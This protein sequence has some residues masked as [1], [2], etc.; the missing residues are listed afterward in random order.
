MKDNRNNVLTAIIPFKSAFYCVECDS[1]YNFD[2]YK[3]EVCPRCANKYCVAL[4]N[5][6][7][8]AMANS[9]EK[10]EG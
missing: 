7:N 4:N 8:L 3:T 1:I 5:F 10:K 9:K 6:R 2:I